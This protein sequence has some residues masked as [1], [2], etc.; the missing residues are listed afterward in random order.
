MTEATV[1]TA[2]YGGGRRYE[3]RSSSSSLQTGDSKESYI[4]SRGAFDVSAYA[5]NFWARVATEPSASAVFPLRLNQSWDFRQAWR[6]RNVPASRPGDPPPLDSIEIRGRTTVLAM[7]EAVTV[8][9]GTFHCVKLSEDRIH[10]TNQGAQGRLLTTAW[11]AA[12][13][14]AV[15]IEEV[16]TNAAG[17]ACLT[18]ELES[19][20]WI[21]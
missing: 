10:R 9:M 2:N 8:P 17:T 1:C 4:D 16:A 11:Y 12:G 18:R 3:T 21:R 20:T 6:A 5:E 14:G 13:I 19:V 7:D 15:K